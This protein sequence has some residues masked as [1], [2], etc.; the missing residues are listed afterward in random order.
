MRSKLS[1]CAAVSAFGVCAWLGS[2][3]QASGA[4]D[5][6]AKD[7]AKTPTEL[8]AD[9]KSMKKQ[10]QWEDKVMGPDSKR[11]E[12]DRIARAAAIN[13]KAAKD[14][15]DKEKQE[16]VEAPAPRAS[17]RKVEARAEV[18]LPSSAEERALE[19]DSGRHEI[20]PRLSTEA[21]ATPPPPSKPADDK[22]IDKLL[23]EDTPGRKRTSTS[24]KELES[25]LA[26]AKDKPAGHKRGDVVDDLIKSADK[27]PA[28]P[29]PRNEAG[30]PDWARQPEIAP[31]SPPPA[32]VAMRTSPRN[33]G[34][35]HVVQ[36]AGSAGAFATSTPGATRAAS[37]RRG[38]VRPAPVRAPAAAPVAWS[39]P[40]ADTKT[41]ATRD[42]SS[43]TSSARGLTSAPELK[44]EPAS[45]PSATTTSAWSD[46][47]ADSPE[48]RKPARHASPAS[49]PAVPAST[50]K[51][52]EKADPGSRSPGST[53]SGWKDPFTTG[54]SE[55]THAPVAM[56]ELSKS[57][58]SKWD[59]AT[60][61][62]AAHPSTGDSRVGG[63]NVLKKRAAH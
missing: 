59:V 23:R 33:D 61:H 30:L 10:L 25:L 29:A 21:A 15:K 37:N 27:G 41:V 50:T 26:G 43:N 55:S 6:S 17:T 18:A 42:R 40:F 20:S 57:E 45:R 34:V 60:R 58:S 44:K 8:H 47:F 28:M 4:K 56:R 35:I 5:R 52:G 46:P 62:V 1:L 49:A 53:G 14:A 63:W 13:E 24:D 3:A 11:A 39:D 7:K 2:A 22:F 32:P 9:D 31:S 54:P 51:R 12:L 19:A 38:G 48:T 16:A 36:G